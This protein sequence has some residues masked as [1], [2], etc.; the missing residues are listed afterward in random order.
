MKEFRGGYWFTILEIL[1]QEK[2]PLH[3]RECFE[4]LEKKYGQANY[5]NFLLAIKK[6]KK[7][8]VII[9]NK[10]TEEQKK[11]CAEQGIFGVQRRIYFSLPKYSK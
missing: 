6:M 1:E 8:K 5:I 2:R 9:S 11:Q 10:I 4:I 3:G 7:S